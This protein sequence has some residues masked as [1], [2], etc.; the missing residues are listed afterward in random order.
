MRRKLASALMVM[1]LL[2]SSIAPASAVLGLSNCEKVKKQILAEEKRVNTILKYLRPF[3]GRIL[4]GKVQTVATNL[5]YQDFA[6]GIWKIIYNNP[7]CFT[8]T[9]KL[10][11]KTL[12]NYNISNILNLTQLKEYRKTGKCADAVYALLSGDECV[13]SFRYKLIYAK[14]WLSVYSN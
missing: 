7:K 2:G 11:T 4:T 5:Y 10:Y 9:Q 1:S 3:E 14:E 12:Q 6:H 8:N 13:N